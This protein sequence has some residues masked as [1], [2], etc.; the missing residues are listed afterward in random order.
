NLKQMGLA[1]HNYHDTFNCMPAGFWRRIYS[2]GGTFTGPGWGWGAAILPQVEQG[3]LY[4]ALGVNTRFNSDPD[5]ILQTLSQTPLTVYRCPS[6]PGDDQNTALPN[7]AGQAAGITHSLSTY[8]GVFG[9]LNTQ[10]TYTSTNLDGCSLF[11]GSC[12]KGGNGMFSPNS[13]VKF[14]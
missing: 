2:E 5:P 13:S 6:A 14:R 9:D 4:D 10:A 1:M 12:I 11:Q 3:G 8:K 7:A